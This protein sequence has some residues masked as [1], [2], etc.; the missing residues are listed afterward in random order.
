[1]TIHEPDLSAARPNYP[2]SKSAATMVLQ[3]I[4]RDVPTTDMQ[5]LSF[6]PGAIFTGAAG[7]AGY[8]RETLNWD[9]GK[10]P[11]KKHTRHLDSSDKF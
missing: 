11:P 2:A 7:K 4:A 10:N 8:T 1:M 3:Q 5:I 9:D 6:H